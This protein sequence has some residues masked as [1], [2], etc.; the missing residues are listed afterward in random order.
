MLTSQKSELLRNLLGG[1]PAGTA[2]LLAKAIENDKRSGGHALP[3]DL[4]LGALSPALTKASV[5][6]PTALRLF[7][8]P[9]A[10]FLTADK[11]KEKQKGRIA[12]ASLRAAWRW[13]ARQLAPEAVAVYRA[14]IAKLA[15]EGKRD[16]AYARAAIFRAFAAREMR[17]AIARDRKGARA[18]LGGETALA[19][20]AEIALLLAAGAE[21]V[22]AQN[23]LPRNTPQL[24]DELL[25]ALRDIHDRVAVNVPD[26]APYIACV[27]MARLAHPWE[28]LKLPQ[29]V[30][31]QTQDTLIANTDMGLVG[32]L[33]FAMIERCGS[34]VRAARHPSFDVEA[35]I[36]DLAR[37][38]A[39]S[40]AIVKEIEMRR[41]G[42]WGKRLLKDRAAVAETMEGLM[43]H[44]P[45]EILAMLPVLRTGSFG[46]GPKAADFARPVDEDK[47][48]RGLRYARLLSGVAPYAAAGSFGAAHKDALDEVSKHLR[49]YN[50]DVIREIRTEDPARRAVVERQFELAVRTTALLFSQTEAE[51]LARRAK[52][53]LQPA[54]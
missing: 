16:E 24:S 26:A 3:H 43:E 34:A 30:A 20:A 19:D 50:E 44:A 2:A 14:E 39:L 42:V 17:E 23:L 7:G 21:I 32:D 38:T 27:A 8:L 29:M 45:R 28:A 46:G 33:L 54:A 18:A 36:G 41:D 51:F 9:F 12:P 53:A 6:A 22:E 11:A 5:R 47:A 31:R 37:F 25:R 52:A 10:D 15:A 1:L 35:L 4:I 13:L 49:G 40:S 48:E